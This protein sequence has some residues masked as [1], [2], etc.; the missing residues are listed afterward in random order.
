MSKLSRS[1][2]KIDK[3]YQDEGFPIITIKWGIYHGNEEDY[4]RKT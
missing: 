2:M 1:Q 3:T 4:E